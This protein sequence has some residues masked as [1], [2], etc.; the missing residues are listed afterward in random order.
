MVWFITIIALLSVSFLV[1]TFFF[2]L[3]I[4]VSRPSAKKKLSPW[5]FACL[6]FVSLPSLCFFLPISCLGQGLL[7]DRYLAFFIYSESKGRAA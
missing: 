6:V 1:L 7:I 4:I 3:F 5:I 2:K